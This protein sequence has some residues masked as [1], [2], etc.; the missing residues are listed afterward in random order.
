[1]SASTSTKHKKAK[2]KE[3]KPTTS[4]NSGTPSG[5]NEGIDQSWAFQPPQGAKLITTN[6]DNGDFDWE[7]VKEDDDVEIWVMRVPDNVKPKHLEGL[8]LDLSGTSGV[9]NQIGSLKRKHTTYDIWSLGEAADEDKLVDA[10]TIVGGEEIKSIS[11]LLPRKS[12]KGKLYLAP[13]PISRHLILSARPPEPSTSENVGS[14]TMQH[15][16]PPRQKYPPE[17]LKHRFMPYGSL[18]GLDYHH[19]DGP[20]EAEVQKRE[21]GD[22]VEE[23]QGADASMMQVDDNDAAPLPTPEATMDGKETKTKNKTKKDKTAAKANELKDAE[24]IEAENPESEAKEKKSSKKRKGED[25]ASTKKSKK[26]K[27]SSR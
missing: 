18:S 6:E 26:A 3:P 4:E 11:C 22:V 1:M 12:K 25:Q 8:S 20:S 15:K 5:K 16:N 14:S 2:T 9:T 7:A 17:V 23:S 13:K 21:D 27:T 19:T 24:M 10:S